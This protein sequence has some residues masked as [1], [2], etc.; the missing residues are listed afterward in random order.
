MAGLQGGE[1]QNIDKEF[2]RLW[3]RANCDP[4]NDPVGIGRGGGGSV[5]LSTL[6]LSAAGEGRRGAVLRLD[7]AG[8]GAAGALDWTL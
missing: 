6:A 1:P 4:Y 3:F 2:L 7:L 5:M 8:Q